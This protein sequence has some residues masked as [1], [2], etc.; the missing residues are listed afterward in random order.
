MD[1]KMKSN[2]IEENKDKNKR[3]LKLIYIFLVIIII[4]IVG[5][6]IFFNINYSKNSKAEKIFGNEYCEAVMHMATRDLVKHNCKICGQEF[7][8][9]SMREDICTQCAKDTNRCEFCA[10]KAINNK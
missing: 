8:D 5:I 6:M 10:K 3:N 7:E 2:K 1:E 4:G 9:S